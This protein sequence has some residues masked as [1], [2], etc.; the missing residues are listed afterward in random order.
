MALQFNEIGALHIATLKHKSTDFH[1]F[2]SKLIQLFGTT[3]SK[4][5][6][7]IQYGH[8]ALDHL[9]HVVHAQSWPHSFSS[10]SFLALGLLL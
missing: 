6:T 7:E 2:H 10:M 4:H 8:V 1:P 3:T 9:H 5:F